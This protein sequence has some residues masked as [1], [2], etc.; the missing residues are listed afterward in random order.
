MVR[1]MVLPCSKSFASIFGSQ[2]V[3]NSGLVVLTISGDIS[4]NK[5]KQF[6]YYES[7]QDDTNK[8]ALQNCPVDFV[9]CL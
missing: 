2:N 4:T 6:E 9:C 7:A 1:H 3:Q 5:G 8:G